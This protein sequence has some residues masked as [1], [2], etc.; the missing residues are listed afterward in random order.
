MKRMC[1]MIF[2]VLLAGVVGTALGGDDKPPEPLQRKR[3]LAP[4]RGRRLPRAAM[5]REREHDEN[6]WKLDERP[7]P[8]HE[9][10]GGRG[11]SD[12]DDDDDD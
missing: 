9:R 3:E 10:S 12:K 7:A 1:A 6:D 2:V 4:T 8:K 11:D 5:M